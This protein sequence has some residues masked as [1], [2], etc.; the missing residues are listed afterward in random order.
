MR[1]LVFGILFLLAGPASAEQLMAPPDVEAGL[2]AGKIMLVDVRTPAEWAETGVATGARTIDMRAPDF[3]E[4]IEAL[5]AA[6]PDKQ[7][8]FICRTGHRS[9]IVVQG[10]EAQGLKDLINVTEGMKGSDKGPGWLARK[11]PVSQPQ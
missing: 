4:Q 3:L 8:A 2:E 5:K 7:L 10:L 11:L 9:T 6:N 1:K